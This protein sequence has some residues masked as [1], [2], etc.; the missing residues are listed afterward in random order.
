M[1]MDFSEP[2]HESSKDLRGHGSVRIQKDFRE[3]PAEWK[4]T[5]YKDYGKLPTHPLP[6]PNEEGAFFALV[7]DRSS[8]RNFTDANIPLE[9]LSS[10]LAYTCGQ[11]PCEPSREKR[12]RAYP[13]AG[14]RYP[15]EVYPL[16]LRSMP[17]LPAGVYHYNVRDHALDVLWEREFA[18]ADIAKL[19][20][21]NWVQR[22]SVVIILTGVFRRI[23]QKYGERGYRYVVLEAGHIGQNVYLAS[24]ELGLKCCELAGTHD[25]AI[26]KLLEIDGVTESVLHAIVIGK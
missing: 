16:V 6:P 26:E 9:E 3:W 19:F 12:R 20:T 13:S 7:K 4:S 18:P 1:P 8:R 23:K 5:F 22:A 14:A 15:I 11:L 21:Y 10:L 17:G 24:S 25:G 2:F